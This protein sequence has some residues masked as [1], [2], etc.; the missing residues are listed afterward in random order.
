MV[1]R[2]ANRV[3]PGATKPEQGRSTAASGWAL[4]EEH[5]REIDQTTA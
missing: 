4:T 3:I 5:I 2:E 1:R